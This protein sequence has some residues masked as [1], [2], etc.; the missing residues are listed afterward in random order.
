MASFD[1]YPQGSSFDGTDLPPSRPPHPGS[2]PYGRSTPSPGD[3]TSNVAPRPDAQHRGVGPRA[4][5][6]LESRTFRFVESLWIWLPLFGLGLLSWAGFSYA[7]FRTRNWRYAKIAGLYFG[8]LL[9]FFALSAILG[10]SSPLYVIPVLLLLVLWFGPTIHGAVLRRTVLREIAA[11]GRWYE[12]AVNSGRAKPQF[13]AQT[14]GTQGPQAV[15]PKQGSVPINH[16]TVSMISSIPGITTETA[17]W[18]VAVRD[19][20]GSFRD[21]HDLVSTAGLPHHDVVRIENYVHFR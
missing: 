4:S 20:H 2:F 8:L 18:I 13:A 10:P 7:A 1:P 6:P 16:A 17:E 15:I 12:D 9:L 19:S 11:Q 3:Q 21:L 14:G 5:S